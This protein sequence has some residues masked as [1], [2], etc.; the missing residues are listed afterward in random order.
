MLGHQI[1]ER[2]HDALE[3]RVFR[4][5]LFRQIGVWDETGMFLLTIRCSEPGFAAGLMLGSA[6][7]SLG[8]YAS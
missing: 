2:I 3:Q 4:L 7:R 6:S 5:L 1:A 8:R